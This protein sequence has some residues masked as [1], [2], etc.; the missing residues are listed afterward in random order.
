MAIKL[1]IEKAYNI[2]E[3]TFIKECWLDL[4]FSEQ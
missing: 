1:E 4:G 3:Q 2:L